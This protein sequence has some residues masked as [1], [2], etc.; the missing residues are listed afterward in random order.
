MSNTVQGKFDRSM[1]ISDKSRKIKEIAAD[2]GAD[3]CGIAGP[4]KF[5]NAPKGTL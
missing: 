1:E 4:D 3:L 2:L 5:N